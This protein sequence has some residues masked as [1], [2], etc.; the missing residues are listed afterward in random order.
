MRLTTSRADEHESE[1]RSIVR[2]PVHKAGSCW[3]ILVSTLL[4]CGVD[5]VEGAEETDS[6]AEGPV[7]QT[8][9]DASTSTTAAQTTTGDSTS[10]GGASAT[11]DDD[12][13]TTGDSTSHGDESTTTMNESTTTDDSTTSGDPSEGS[14]GDE[15]STGVE[16]PL[17]PPDGHA[18]A[19]CVF[20]DGRIVLA[21][22][23]ALS[24]EP[25]RASIRLFDADG[26]ELWAV[27]FGEPELATYFREV[28]CVEDGPIYAAG[29]RGDGSKWN[30]PQALLVRIDPQT[31]G[32]DWDLLEPEIPSSGF[33]GLH[34]D[35]SGVYVTG[36]RAGEGGSVWRFDS[37]GNED[38]LLGDGIESSE[39][40]RDALLVDDTLYAV[41]DNFLGG[42]L[43]R[44]T[45]EGVVLGS[46]TF[47]WPDD[48]SADMVV[49]DPSGGVIV[50]GRRE[51]GFFDRVLWGLAC[52]EDAC[53]AE[54]V[55]VVEGEDI[56]HG[57]AIDEAGRWILSGESTVYAVLAT[58]AP[59]WESDTDFDWLYTV[60]R[61]NLL[62]I[63]GSGTIVV[64]GGE[65]AQIIRFPADTLPPM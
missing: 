49:P 16:P 44:L 54:R 47:D 52:N 50:A 48:V 59:V 57:F 61:R 29:L 13:T 9:V 12:S 4:A 34:A 62:A 32:T 27:G 23:E 39:V 26:N 17:P 33:E 45:P 10:S 60:R 2:G 64:A 24:I 41:G 28:A 14:S 38:W 36:W 1:R 42:T 19:L 25:G 22:S 58:G 31:G 18:T 35:A 5:S 56:L 37:D 3:L 43:V 40:L 21:T 15:S 65:P 6:A 30:L 46:E 7:D 53:A 8:T 11:L 51:T 20:E 63:D 55:E